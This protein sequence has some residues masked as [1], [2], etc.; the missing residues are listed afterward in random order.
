MELV[1]CCPAFY[2]D[3]YWVGRVSGLSLEIFFLRGI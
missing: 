3:R 1:S 2:E